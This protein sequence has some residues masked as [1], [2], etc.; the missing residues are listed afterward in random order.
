MVV[1]LWRNSSVVIAALVLGG[2]ALPVPIQIASWAI[3]GISYIATQKSIT[4]HGLSM[5]AGRDCAMHRVVT[6]GDICG[7]D[8]YG[9]L[10]LASLAVDSGQSFEPVS[11]SRDP[12]LLAYTLPETQATDNASRDVHSA[13]NDVVADI[14]G[15][16]DELNEPNLGMYSVRGG[17]T[18]PVAVV[19]EAETN[20]RE[21]ETLG[22]FETSAG[23]ATGVE[24]ARE[25]EF[26]ADAAVPEGPGM[27]ALWQT[28]RV[29]HVAIIV[30]NEPESILPEDRELVTM[31]DKGSNSTITLA[32]DAGPIITRSSDSPK[33]SPF[34]MSGT[35]GNVV[36]IVAGER[37]TIVM[38]EETGV[39]D[40][41][42]NPASRE[43][44]RAGAQF[45]KNWSVS[46]LPVRSE[47]RKVLYAA[48]DSD[49][50]LSP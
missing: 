34:V 26:M 17:I 3:D 13:P 45:P 7:D 44:G 29:E 38:A 24:G 30:S 47:R 18:T 8:P 16:L 46:S 31:W 23:P 32:K 6:E 11:E 41:A 19:A 5:V 42:L 39:E 2:C 10:E 33:V 36:S 15:E 37:S 9:G 49:R 27:M 20:D 4:D 14:P 50:L 28:G 35:I 25:T 12:S 48:S 21:A 40:D 1:R 43:S 22:D